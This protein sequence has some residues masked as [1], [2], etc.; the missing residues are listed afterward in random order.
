MLF[1]KDFFKKQ[2]YMATIA[3][4]ALQD[5]ED[6]WKLQ[7]TLDSFKA[8]KPEEQTAYLSEW[9]MLKMASAIENEANRKQSEIDSAAAMD[10]RKKAVEATLKAEGYKV[11]NSASDWD[12]LYN[13]P[14]V[15]GANW[16][17]QADY[18]RSIAKSADDF[19]Q[20]AAEVKQL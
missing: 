9:M 4:K 3:R 7:T 10:A 16:K 17:K 18:Q 8:I 14:E 5:F 2:K 19:I 13:K 20:K 6:T 11:D 12:K 15:Y 1:T